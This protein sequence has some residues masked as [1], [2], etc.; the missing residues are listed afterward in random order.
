MCVTNNI[1]EKSLEKW[2][3]LILA[4]KN[5]YIDSVPTGMDDAVYDML[6][7]RAAQEDGFFVRDYVYQ[8]YLK[9]TKTKNSYIEKIKKKKVEEKTMLSALSEFMN[10]N[11]GKYCDLKYDGSSI[12]IYLDSSTGIP[13]RIVTVG[14]LN[15]DNYGVDQTW[16]LINFLPKRFP[17][18]IVAIQAEALV[19][20]NR[21][22]DTDPETA[23]QRA[24]GL[25]N[26][27]YCESEVNNLL[28]LRAYRYY[29]DDSI[30]GQILRK[31]DYREVLK[32]FETVCS[33]TDG[34][35]LFSPAD[36][37]T[38]K[39][40]MSA[41]NKEYTETDKTVTSTGYFLNDGWVVYDEFGICLGALKFAGA[42][43]GTEA[44]KTTVRGI[45]WNSQVAKGKDSWSANILIDP[46][47]VKGCT[48][49]KPSAGSVG[50][51][52]KKKITPGAIVSIIMAN[53][54]IPMVGDSFTEGNG[55][56]MW[57]TCSCGYNMSEK[58]VYGSL[59]KCGN[60]MCT[61]RLDRMNNYIGSL[62]NIKQQLDLNKLLVIDRFKWESTRINIDQLL[63]S[64]ERNDPNSYY[65]QLRSYLKTD[66]Q[67][68]NL[69][70]VWKASYTIL[71]S[72]YEKSI[73]I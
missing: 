1:T 47:Q 44:L 5:Y 21:L 61:E 53:S 52:V 58:D 54:T 7:A 66:L 71:R 35:I 3:D 37:W 42:G 62:S 25:I 26:S 18:G 4:C 32:M 27:K 70:L 16:K 59:L 23:R 31:T 34:H 13:K 43:S 63:G 6:E 67:V 68:R 51:M 14:N 41:G 11:S 48:V 72:Y 50:K 20:I 60:P 65:N 49:R 22:S 56:F 64:V 2:K 15:L 24:N 39:E 29:T 36:V 69:D 9:G 55:D 10:E 19:D 28:T 46:I 30:E 45:Q 73:G 57:P 33:K 12:A 17:K 8:T 40:L 38:I